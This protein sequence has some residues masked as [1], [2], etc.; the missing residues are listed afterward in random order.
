LDSAKAISEPHRANSGLHIPS[1]DGIRAIAAFLVFVSHAGLADVIPGG[2][3]V[4]IF[5]FLSGYLITTLLRQEYEQTGRI[6]LSNFYLRRIFRIIPPLYI[7]LLLL[8][9]LGRDSAQ[10]TPGALAMQFSQLTNYYLILWGNKH[11]IPDSGPTWSLAVEE[12]FYLVFPL[13]LIGLLRF[14]SRRLISSI[15]LLLCAAVLLWRCW[16]IFGLKVRYDYTYYATDTRFDSLLYGCLMAV[17]MNPALDSGP[18]RV[19]N[20]V[21]YIALAAGLGLLGL[22]FVYRSEA[23]RATFRY[24]IQ[25]MALAPLFLTAICRSQ[26]PIYRWL[27]WKPVRF[28]G[29]ISYTFYLSHL[30]ALGLVS[31]YYHGSAFVRGMLGFALAVAFSGAMYYLI[32][33]HLATLRRRLHAILPARPRE[34]NVAAARLV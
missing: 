23:F 12:H 25:G 9:L 29:L 11:L 7:V 31:R 3:G 19:S 5:F 21:W 26:W 33:R 4:T 15:L 8:L 16:L 28:M 14:R 17:A 10:V 24:S 20:R 13:L 30:R 6:S 22:T 18:S 2:F 32:E 34:V 27:E 1:L